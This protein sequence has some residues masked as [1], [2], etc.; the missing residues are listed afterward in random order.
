M[1]VLGVCENGQYSL[2]RGTRSSNYKFKNYTVKPKM[3]ENG[4]FY[5]DDKLMKT[6]MK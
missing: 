2:Y 1:R 3:V 5:V 4:W 6:L